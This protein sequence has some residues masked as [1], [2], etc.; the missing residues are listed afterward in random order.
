MNAGPREEFYRHIDA[1]NIDLKAFTEGFYRDITKGQLEPVK[2][3]LIYLKRETKV[4]FEITTLLIPGL[5]DSDAEIISLSEWIVDALGPDI[6]LHFSAFKP[7]FRMKDRPATPPETL[8]RARRLAR[9]AGVRHVYVGNI[10]APS[11]ASTWCHACGGSLI[12][13]DWYDILEWRLGPDGGCPD[14]GTP[15]PGVFEEKPGTW[16]RKRQRVRLAP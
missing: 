6:P 3:T 2:E 1:A 13:R 8:F 10:H 16:G 7:D 4:W 9:A 11:R 15:L 14:C 5:N 12:K